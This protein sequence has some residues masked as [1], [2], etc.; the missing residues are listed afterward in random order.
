ERGPVPR[1]H[2]QT[3]APRARRAIQWARPHGPAEISRHDLVDLTC[4]EAELE[5]TFM[6]YYAK[7]KADVA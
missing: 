7:E 5:E 1:P 6:A 3:G 2:D 4:V